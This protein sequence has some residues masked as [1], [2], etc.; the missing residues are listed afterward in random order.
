MTA[1]LVWLVA[2][3]AA[4]AR[5]SIVRRGGAHAKSEAIGIVMTAIVATLLAIG[6]REAAHAHVARQL[7]CMERVDWHWKREA[8]CRIA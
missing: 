6:A 8:G 2:F 4:W 1:F 3:T 7:V 5:I